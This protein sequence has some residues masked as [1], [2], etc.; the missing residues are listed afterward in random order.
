MSLLRCRSLR[1]CG[2]SL[3]MLPVVLLSRTLKFSRES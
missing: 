3:I 1:L 2:L